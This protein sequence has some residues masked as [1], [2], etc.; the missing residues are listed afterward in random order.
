M[1]I[2]YLFPYFIA[3]V[4]PE[5]GGHIIRMEDRTNFELE[6]NRLDSTILKMTS[7]IQRK[8]Q[9]YQAMFDKQ[10]KIQTKKP[11]EARLQYA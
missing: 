9:R 11:K 5:K 10:K 4:V 7:K 8:G 2:I 1:W 6:A 3:I